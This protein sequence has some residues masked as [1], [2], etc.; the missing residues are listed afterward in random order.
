VEVEATCIQM[1]SEATRQLI[2]K[3]SLFITLPEIQGSSPGMKGPVDG[4]HRAGAAGPFMAAA[5]E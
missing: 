2:F 4:S 1:T 5:P 3:P